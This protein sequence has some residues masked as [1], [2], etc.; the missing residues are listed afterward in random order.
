MIKKLVKGK[1]SIFIDASNIYFSQKKLKW[2]I[3]F[4]KKLD[5]FFST[6]I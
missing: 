1:T 5:L 3:D 2:R 6:I 4:E